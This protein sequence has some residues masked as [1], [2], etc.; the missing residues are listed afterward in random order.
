MKTIFLLTA[1]MLLSAT[2]YAGGVCF[3]LK[4]KKTGHIMIGKIIIKQGRPGDVYGNTVFFK[5]DIQGGDSDEFYGRALNSQVT[6]TSD[7]IIFNKI[8]MHG[9]GDYFD[10]SLKLTADYIS[11]SLSDDA[12]KY[13]RINCPVL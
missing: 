7:A 6:Q 13:M 3:E 12:P 10:L 1:V 8:A 9:V 2:A 4:D 11:L 5:Q